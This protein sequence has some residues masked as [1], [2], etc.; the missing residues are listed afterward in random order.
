MAGRGNDRGRGRGMP[1]GGDRG[2]I[3]RGRGGRGGSMFIGGDRGGRGGAG[4]GLPL[5]GRGSRGG[6]N[7]NQDFHNRRGGSFGAG[8]DRGGGHHQPGNNLRG[9]GSGNRGG[10]SGGGVALGP[11]DAASQSAAM[12]GTGGS[13]KENRRTLT[14]FKLAGI[15]I[16]DLKWTWGMV[17][18]P[19]SS[20]VETEATAEPAVAGVSDAPVVKEEPTEGDAE[21]AQTQPADDAA[22]SQSL[23]AENTL[24]VEPEDPSHSS[25]G[26]TASTTVTAHASASAPESVSPPPSRVRIYFHT[27][28]SADDSHPIPHAVTGLSITPSDSRKGKRKKLEDDDGDLEEG[29]ARRPPPQP[30]SQLGKAEPVMNIDTDGTARGSVAPSVGDTASM[31]EA[32]WLMAAIVE[33]DG[34]ADAEGD[35]DHDMLHVSQ[36]VEEVDEPQETGGGSD[37]GEPALLVCI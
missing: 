32:D 7:N 33:D 31:S 11:R 37:D 34:N 35:D 2:G 26:K 27:P 25:S 24:I 22:A 5:R 18:P 9:R 36:I 3:G 30:S 4:Q 15:Q 6:F 23:K 17:P 8:G 28:V 1:M 19:P 20:V 29:R 13:G 12:G 21:L 14:D 16:D 10:G